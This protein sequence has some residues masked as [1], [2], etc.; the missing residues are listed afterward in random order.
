MKKILLLFLTVSMATTLFGQ[1]GT[2]TFELS[3]G[4]MFPFGDLAD[5]NLSDSSSGAAATGYHIQVGYSFQL[6]DNF[7]VGIDVEFN[8]T[9]Y[10]MNKV[11]KYYDQLL[12]DARKEITSTAGWTLGG[13]Y[14]RYY[15][16]FRLGSLT[17]LDVSPLIGGMGVYSPEYQIDRT[18]FLP[19]GPNPTETYYRQRSKTFSFAYGISTK[20]N[21]KIKNHGLF[22]EARFIRSQ[23][24]FRH[25]TGTGY[26]GKPYD[27]SVKMD[28]MYLTSSL[29]YAYYF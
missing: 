4:A 8:D 18:S 3:A 29:G 17:T 14:L 22:L 26:D 9:R 13:I 21:F 7:G 2:Q 20:L 6:S 15:I 24:N 1:A 10:S 11:H 25:V 5:Y 12:D 28:V 19:P 16:H 27:N 23:P